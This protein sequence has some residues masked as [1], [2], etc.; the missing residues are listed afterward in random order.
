MGQA[1]MRKISTFELIDGNLIKDLLW[2]NE[3][4]KNI[5]EKEVGFFLLASGYDSEMF[6]FTFG[7]PFYVLT[8]TIILAAVILIINFIRYRCPKTF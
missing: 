2:L 7:L 1:V 6:Q 8:F 3:E 5:K 4:T